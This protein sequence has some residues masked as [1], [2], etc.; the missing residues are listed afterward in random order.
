MLILKKI[1]SN[2]AWVVLVFV[3]L[4]TEVVSFSADNGSLGMHLN[5]DKLW[6]ETKELSDD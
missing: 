1:L 6:N 3:V 4:L 5:Y 2:I